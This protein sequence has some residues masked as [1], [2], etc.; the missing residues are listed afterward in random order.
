[1]KKNPSQRLYEIWESV[2]R[3]YKDAQIASSL[4]LFTKFKT[5]KKVFSYKV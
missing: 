5:S 3:V 1:M 4:K 2:G